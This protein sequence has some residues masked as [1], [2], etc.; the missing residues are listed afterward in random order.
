MTWEAPNAAETF[1]IFKQKLLLVC[2]DNDV[3][4]PKKVARKIQIGINDE[5]LRRLNA[6]S[7]SEVDKEDPAK[8]WKF[9][10][11]QLRVS[12]NFRI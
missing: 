3:Q 9:F 1:R 8:L 11:D 4:D 6:S 12:V 7:L 10:E 2:E 5:G